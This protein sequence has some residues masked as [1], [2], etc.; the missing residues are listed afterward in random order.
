MRITVAALAA[1]G[2]FVLGNIPVLA[3]I[4]RSQAQA[5]TVMITEPG[6]NGRDGDGGSGVLVARTG[7]RYQVLTNCHV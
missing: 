6:E 3:Q 7:D 1:S 5:V 2:S 4:T